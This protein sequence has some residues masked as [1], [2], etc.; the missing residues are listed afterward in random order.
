MAVHCTL[1]RQVACK[2]V[3]LQSIRQ[4]EREKWQ[5]IRRSGGLRSATVRKDL[6]ARAEQA[7]ARQMREI[8]ILKKISHVSRFPLQ[9]T[10][11]DA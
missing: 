10:A 2:V 3:S 9:F 1:R 6:K 8:E 7:I 11:A 5:R 4:R